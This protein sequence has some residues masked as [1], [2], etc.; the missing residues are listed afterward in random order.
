MVKRYLAISNWVDK[1]TGEVKTSLGEITE[2]ISAEGNSYQITETKRTMIVNEHM[3]V[4]TIV[5][6]KMA[7]ETPEKSGK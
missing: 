1:K 3:P 7:L 5:S 4:G 6:Y 2:G